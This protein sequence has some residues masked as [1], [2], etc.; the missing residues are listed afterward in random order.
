MSFLFCL[1]NVTN[2]WQV[3]TLTSYNDNVIPNGGLAVDVRKHVL[4]IGDRTNNAVWRQDLH[5]GQVL[6]LAGGAD[7]DAEIKQQAANPNPQAEGHETAIFVSPRGLCL[8]AGGAHLVLFD[9]SGSAA[10]LRL[11]SASTGEVL[12]VLGNP[13]SQGILDGAGD[14]A[15]LSSGSWLLDCLP[16][17]TILMADSQTRTVRRICPPGWSAKSCAEL[18]GGGHPAPPPSP[19]TPPAGP[20]ADGSQSHGGSSWWWQ[21]LLFLTGVVLGGGLVAGG[22]AAAGATSSFVTTRIMALRARHAEPRA[23]SALPVAYEVRTLH[24]QFHMERFLD[25]FS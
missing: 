14:K 18:R 23:P 2:E 4:Y 8:A 11:V 12:T 15:A 24:G 16:D 13:G 19:D 10:V 1:G 9:I 7:S 17:S 21:A 22:K 20:G 6:L 5:T 3:V 25:S